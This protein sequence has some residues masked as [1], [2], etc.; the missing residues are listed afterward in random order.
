[1]TESIRYPVTWHLGSRGS[2][3]ALWQ[4]GHVR[5][6]LLEAWPGLAVVVETYSTKG[7]QILN[8]PLPELG[9]KGLF[10]AELESALRQGAIDAA[11]HSLKDLP[12][13]PP[14]GL[15]VGAIPHRENPADVLIS[16]NGYTMESLPIGAIVGT[17]SR[18]R[19]A[20]IKNQ[21]PD[22]H[23]ADIRGNVPTRIRKAFDPD[24]PYEA[25]ILAY[26]GLKRLGRM[27][28]VS[29]I[30]P[31]D[32]FLPAPGQGALGVQCRDED[33]SRTMLLPLNSFS[34]QVAVVAERAFLSG[35][36]GG[37]ALP[38]A[39][40]ADLDGKQLAL[41]GRITSPDGTRQ[42]DLVSQG[43]PEEAFQLGADLALE[44]L[45][46]G[47]AELLETES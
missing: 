8:K 34:S 21:R 15:I 14:P 33:I 31:V 12:V 2:D 6:L 45:E 11:V 22:I 28:A 13:D 27:D 9:G 7:D 47:A 20:Q 23:T 30:L 17:S 29:Q 38:I 5:D 24:G 36:G 25:I 32:S 35:L 39:A 18:R 19:A 41:R 43:S 46:R 1:M 44:A 10:T 37:C 3:L 16:R 26:A 40:Y 4:T 42:L